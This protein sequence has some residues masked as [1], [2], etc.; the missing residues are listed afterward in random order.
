MIGG[1]FGGTG[2]GVPA[3]VTSDAGGV[4][5]LRRNTPIS[6]ADAAGTAPCRDFA[7]V[8]AACTCSTML[9]PSALMV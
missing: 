6:G 2:M 4:G 5:G 3:M 8:S 9:F 7:A 1:N